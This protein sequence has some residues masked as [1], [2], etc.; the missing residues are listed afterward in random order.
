MAAQAEARQAEIGVPNWLA[1]AKAIRELGNVMG[2]LRENIA[3]W[4]DII[5]DI[6]QHQHVAQCEELYVA[7]KDL[8]ESPSHFLFHI[9]AAGGR[10][11]DRLSDED[12]RNPKVIEAVKSSAAAFSGDIVSVSTG[13]E[14]VYRKG[15]IEG[16]DAFLDLRRG[17]KQRQ[18]LLC[19]LSC[20][21][22]ETVDPEAV[23]DIG[24][25]YKD[26]IVQLDCLTDALHRYLAR[27][28]D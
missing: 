28:A 19:E 13:L 20:I 22:P 14:A 1:L 25:A 10:D 21:D 7:L 11:L 5:D 26:L 6:S 18:E 27:F 17:L 2:L 12:L 16:E 23:R 3:S 15:I 8:K 24:R 9:K 4:Y